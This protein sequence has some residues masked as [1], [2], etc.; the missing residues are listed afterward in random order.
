[1]KRIKNSTVV[2]VTS[3]NPNYYKHLN[4]DLVIVESYYEEGKDEEPIYDLE[5][6]DSSIKMLFPFSLYEWEFEVV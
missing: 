2:R 3:D 4:K 1:M 6:K 5:F